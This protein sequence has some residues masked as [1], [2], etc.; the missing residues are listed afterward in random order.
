[1]KG[2]S[3]SS[4][5]ISQDAHRGAR[6]A[7]PRL[8]CSPRGHW[9]AAKGTGAL[10]FVEAECVAPI[11]GSKSSWTQREQGN[12]SVWWHGATGWDPA[13]LQAG[14]GLT[15]LHA[16]ISLPCKMKTNACQP[17][18]RRDLI[19]ECLSSDLSRDPFNERF[20]KQCKT[21]FS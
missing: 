12:P 13:L 16:L 6:P 15:E 3:R 17:S 14:W 20:H 1:M 11:F 10:K 2:V 19:N 9:A 4:Q 8:P 5:G 21:S 7:Q 18:A